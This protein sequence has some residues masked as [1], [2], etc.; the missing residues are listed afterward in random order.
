MSTWSGIRKRM[1][2]EYLAESLKGDI[3]YF[4]TSYSRSPDHEG[5]AAIRYDG[6]E[7]IKGCYYHN[8]TKAESFP[9]DEKYERRMREE[10]AYIDD[11]AIKLG[12]FDQR[13]FYRA[14]DEFD[15]QSI[16][17]SLYSENMLVRIFAVLDR[18][19]GKRKLISMKESIE[20]EPD[21]I[22]EFFAIRMNAEGI[23]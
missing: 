10:F 11:T 20:N 9:K 17:K 7:I 18:R 6:K 19:V 4:A 8:W 15:N 23:V 3:S 22:K 5:R 14:F 13:C 12:V 16:E 21:S 1:E 2:S